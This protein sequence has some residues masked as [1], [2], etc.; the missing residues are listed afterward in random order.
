MQ[1]ENERNFPKAEI[2][3]SGPDPCLPTR[4][5]PISWITHYAAVRTRGVHPPYI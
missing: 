2:P 4:Y 1:P 5:E 3:W